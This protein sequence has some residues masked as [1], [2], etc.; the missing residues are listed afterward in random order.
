MQNKLTWKKQHLVHGKNSV[1]Y[2]ITYSWQK[3]V[4]Q[5]L[6]LLLFWNEWPTPT[7]NKILEWPEISKWDFVVVLVK[8]LN[9]KIIHLSEI[10]GTWSLKL[11]IQL[12]LSHI[13]PTRLFY[14]ASQKNVE[15]NCST[16]LRNVRKVNFSLLLNLKLPG[17]IFSYFSVT[18]TPY[19]CL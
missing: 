2:T 11:V 9:K 3:A 18:W 5:K 6:W 4:T 1:N 10:L 8:L 13:V 19:H 17:A 16:R 14:I 7:L 15:K 12:T